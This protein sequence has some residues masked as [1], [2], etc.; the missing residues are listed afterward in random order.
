MSR[1]FIWLLEHPNHTYSWGAEKHGVFEP[2]PDGPLADI[3]QYL[4]ADPNELFEIVVLLAGDTIFSTV[5]TVPDQQVK[6]LQQALPFL[7]EEQLAE[8]IADMYLVLGPKVERNQYV[9]MGIT[10]VRLERHLTY[11]AQANIQPHVMVADSACCPPNTVLLTT[12]KTLLQLVEHQT[13][14]I[15]SNNT[16]EVVS[17]YLATHRNSTVDW[18]VDADI[19]AQAS[20]WIEKI[21]ASIDDEM[22]KFNRQTVDNVL[23]ILTKQYK[24]SPA[25]YKAINFLQGKYA[26]KIAKKTPQ[27]RWHQIAL[28]VCVVAA[29]QLLVDISQGVYLGVK[30]H[31]LEQQAKEFYKK[32]FPN[33]TVTDNVKA[34]MTGKL[35]SAE[36]SGSKNSFLETYSRIV[37]IIN[38]QQLQSSL[39]IVQVSFN[40]EKGEIHMDLLAKSF[41][42][43]TQLKDLLIKDGLQAEI[44]SA[45]TEESKT[46]ASLKIWK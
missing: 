18:V 33:D 35:K 7:V 45:T 30:T 14:S 21:E 5:I 9:V 34:Q 39:D 26:R 42:Q 36:A 23:P 41:D 12:E 44:G 6:Y 11:L 31:Q 19:Q 27:H 8:D 28:V 24:Q 22:T 13:H 16:V 38:A 1:L 17:H 4:H 43:L 29:L 3:A 10:R 2:M 46:K 25:F 37:T 32:I 20:V 15:D 40:D